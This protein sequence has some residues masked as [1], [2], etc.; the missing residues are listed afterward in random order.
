MPRDPIH[1]TLKVEIV[2]DDVEVP[3]KGKQKWVHGFG[4]LRVFLGADQNPPDRPAEL[5]RGGPALTGHRS[6]RRG[7]GGVSGGDRLRAEQCGNGDCL[8]AHPP[9]G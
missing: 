7:W 3:R 6:W 2:Q 4:V 1:Q 9:Q 8:S 5:E